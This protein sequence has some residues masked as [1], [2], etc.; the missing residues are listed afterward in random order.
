MS[1][2]IASVCASFCLLMLVA[3][4]RA[5]SPAGDWE[6]ALDTP[7]GTRNMRASFK[8]EGEKLTGALKGERGELP[9][10]GTIKGNEIKF[11]YTVKYMDQDLPITMTGTID[12]D[13]MK[14]K[15]DFGGF[16][17]GDWTGKRAGAAA[18]AAAPAQAGDVTGTW[19]FEVETPQG[20]G[21]PVI[22]FKQEGE[23]LTGQYKGALGEAPLSGTVKGNQI[24]FS[25]KVSGQLEATIT[26]RGTIEGE[27]MKGTA[28]FGDLGDATWKAK[29]RK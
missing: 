10:N 3:T 15:A 26:Y 2:L 19:D 7:G 9:I 4:A 20:S 11:A 13:S 14:G 8:V 12:G 6:I 29:R 17:E 1:K 21:T 5:Q 23:K 16:A 24:E 22:V 27:T 25:F 18:A 28:K